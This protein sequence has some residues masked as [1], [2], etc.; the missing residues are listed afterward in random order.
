MIP[1]MSSVMSSPPMPIDD[2]ESPPREIERC[3]PSVNISSMTA[4]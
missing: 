4:R 3:P 1:T 2:R